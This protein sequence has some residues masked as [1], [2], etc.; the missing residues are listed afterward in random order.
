MND[1]MAIGAMQAAAA[2]GFTVGRD[3]AIVGFD[4]A[5]MVQYLQPPLTSVRQ[6]I[7]EVGHKVVEI[8]IAL[9][10]GRPPAERQVMLRPELIVRASSQGT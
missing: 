7:R 3:L 4:D 10:E 6:P 5:P 1:T 9:L 2:H 8:L